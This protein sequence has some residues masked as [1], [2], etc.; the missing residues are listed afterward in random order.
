MDVHRNGCFHLAA[1]VLEEQ[2]NEAEHVDSIMVATTIGGKTMR[3]TVEGGHGDDI[4]EFRTYEYSHD[5]GMNRMMKSTIE[6]L[7]SCMG[8]DGMVFVKIRRHES[9]DVYKMPKLMAQDDPEIPEG[10]FRTPKY[11]KRLLDAIA[12]Y[13][14]GMLVRGENEIEASRVLAQHVKNM[15][16]T[17]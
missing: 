11:E 10:T 5:L 17:I 2:V 7:N 1:E 4:Y 13:T 15:M 8:G 6:T 12:K 16:I 14:R 3:Y 9:F